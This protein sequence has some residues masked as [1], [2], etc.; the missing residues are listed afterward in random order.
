M[1]VNLEREQYIYKTDGANPLKS[2]VRPLV[3]QL[4]LVTDSYGGDQPPLLANIISLTEFKA[5]K[6]EHLISQRKTLLPSATF[7]RRL[8]K[9]IL[10]VSTVIKKLQ[11]ENLT[12]T[13][14]PVTAT[15]ESH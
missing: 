15:P 1:P 2:E 14:V 4:R 12:T 9:D 10:Q 7:L 8:R 3:P 6:A 13:Q 5:K 11:P